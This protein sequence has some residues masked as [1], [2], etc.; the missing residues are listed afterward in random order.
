MVKPEI[1]LVTAGA[2]E[3]TLAFP[4]CDLP[5]VYGAGAFQTL[6]NR[7]LIKPTDKLFVIGG[8]NVGLIGLINCGRNATKKAMLLGLS[9]VTMNALFKS[10]RD[11]IF[12]L[13]C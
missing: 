10:D 7:D 8:G 3:K 4:G 9:A 11:D 1:L 12:F 5:G 6:V 13:V 2:R